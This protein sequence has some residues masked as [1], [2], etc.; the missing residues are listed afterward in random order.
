MGA[1]Q[2]LGEESPDSP[3]GAINGAEHI[4]IAFFHPD[5]ANGHHLSLNAAGHFRDHAVLAGELG[6]DLSNPAAEAA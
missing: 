1:F 3:G 2:P 4:L 5:G 6:G